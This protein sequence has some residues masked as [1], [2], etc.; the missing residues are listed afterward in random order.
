MYASPIV[1]TFGKRYGKED[2]VCFK[3]LVHVKVVN[4]IIKHMIEVIKELND[5]MGGA[6]GADRGEA[7]DV[8]EKN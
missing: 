1:S 3:N 6:V 8:T 5:L 2:E 4:A 7:H